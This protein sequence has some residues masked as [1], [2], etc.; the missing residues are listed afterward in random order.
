[1]TRVASAFV[2]GFDADIVRAWI[3][4]D[5]DP[6]TRAEL[7][8]LLEAATAEAGAASAEALADLTDRFSG[9]LEFGTAG[10]RGEI[11]AGPHRMNR[12]V[13]N[14]AAARLSALPSEHTAA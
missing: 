5:P 12:T 6:V 2:A 4:D 3:A 7:S 14:R 10:P 8:E 9:P 1:M 13:L 11:A